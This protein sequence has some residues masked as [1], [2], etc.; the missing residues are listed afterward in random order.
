MIFI[1]LTVTTVSATDN[2]TNDNS[3]NVYESENYDDNSVVTNTISKNVQTQTK[4][5][6][7]E[8]NEKKDL[9][10]TLN[11]IEEV[12]YGNDANISGTFTDINGNPRI[13][14]KL[15]I[16]INDKSASAKT[17]DDGKFYFLTKIGKVGINN[18][19]VSHNGGTNFNPISVNTTYTVLKQ[20]LKITVDPIN[21]TS[22]GENVTITGTFTDENG[23]A[24]NGSKVKVEV[25]GKFG[26]ALVDENGTYTFTTVI[27]KIGI[28]NVT[29]SHKGGANF[30][31]ASINTTY[32][33]VKQDLKI[34]VDPI[35]NVGFGDNV[36][37]TGRFT[38][39]ND[40][41]RVN[42]KV[43]V[44]VNG[45]FGSAKTDS[46]GYFTFVTKLGALGIN[47]VT[48]SHPGGANYNPVDV[49]TTYIVTKQD[50]NINITTFK[51][52]DNGNVTISGIFTDASGK[53]RKNSNVKVVVNGKSVSAKT[54]SKGEF[55]Y[56]GNFPVTDMNNVTI[57]H[58]GGDNYNPLEY[59]NIFENPDIRISDSEIHP[60]VNKTLLVLV[61]TDAA[62]NAVFKIN[63]NTISDK[64]EVVYGMVYYTYPVPES[65]QSEEYLLEFTYSGDNKYM[66]KTV[67]ATLTLTPEGGRID[68]DMSMR[69]FSIKYLV[70]DVI[71]V[72][73]NDDAFGTIQFKAND[74][75]ITKIKFSNG[76]AEYEYTSHLKPGVYNLTAT[77]SG[78]YKYNPGIV[79]S[80]LIVNKLNSKLTMK[81]ITSKAGNY[82]LFMATVTDE[83]KQPVKKMNVTFKLNNTVIG[84]NFTDANGSVKLYY[85][86]PSSLYEKTYNITA[87]GLTTDTV[88]GSTNKAKLTLKQLTTK[89]SVPDTSTKPS[90]TITITATVIDEFNNYVSKGVVT[91]KKDNIILGKVNVSD[92]FAKFTYTTNYETSNKTYVYASYV[93][94]WKYAS[95]NGKG[96]YE[97]TQ[98]KTTISPNAINANP[99]SEIT[100][101]SIIRDQNQNYATDGSVR[102]SIN[103]TVIGTATVRNGVATLRH[104]LKEYVAGNYRIKAEYLGSKVYKP[105]SNTNTMIVSRYGTTIR[106]EEFYA[107]VG[108]KSTMSL[109]VVDDEKYNV[110]S[111]EVKFYLNNEYLGTAKVSNGVATLEYT[112]PSKYDGKTVKYYATYEKNGIYDSSS[113]SGNLVVTHQKTV[114]VSPTGS[115]SN[116]GDKAHPFKTIQYALTHIS[117]FGTI[118]LEPGTY[119]L[120]GLQLNTSVNLIG[121]G[122]DKTFIDGQKSGVPVFNITKRNAVLTI[123]GITIRN[124]KSNND[125]S[126]GAIVTSGKLNIVNSRF[127]N[128]TGSGNFSG[129]AIYTNGILNI[130]NTTFTNNIVTN[131][132]SQGGAIRCYDN[133]TYI[134]NCRFESNQVTGTNSTGASAIYG[135]YCDII[136][137]QTTFTKNIAKGKY[138]TGGVIR[139][140]AGAVVIDNSTFTNNQ[141]ISTDYGMGGIIGS[142]SSGISI[143]NSNINSNTIKATNNAG[144]GAVYVE[145]AA[146]D[147]KNTKINSNTLS[148]ATT[149]GGTIYS[150]KASVNI[151][152][153]QMN[154]NKLADTDNGYGGVVYAYEGGINVTNSNFTSNSIKAKSLALAGAIYTFS[155]VDVRNSNFEKNDINATNLGGG[156]IA[157]MGNLTVTNSNFIS[158]NAYNAGDAITATTSAKNNIENNYWGS[159]NP[160]WSNLLYSV[161]QPKT[162]SKTKL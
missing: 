88:I 33:V 106:G 147:I 153:T 99:N 57:T 73:L 36:T 65:F 123:K 160:N 58:P 38:D 55:T 82:T 143:M 61:P 79:N 13:N 25:N 162:Y 43:K 126:A 142:L 7:T 5:N 120:S 103:N 148:A 62:G 47:N 23:I 81:N 37:I 6:T 116:L 34:T 146:M 46:D 10:I 26:S 113:Y 20:D 122:R 3:L 115:D 121:S 127:V 41:P 94:D 72:E 92:G 117:L 108:S 139:A 53:V 63:K 78:N 56:T 152:D 30:N 129:G 140:I 158:N 96:T 67:N 15:K 141:I 133:T 76:S 2:I 71:S 24:R 137:N 138:V 4:T 12:K 22:F 17:N 112:V 59:N 109:S 70:K 31:P 68:A 136:I 35:A 60:G 51:E 97:V 21:Q 111:G 28:N 42:S 107:V 49:N 27:G 161:S 77:Y 39:A 16:N 124:A 64:L 87:T 9:S 104:T 151:I 18:V 89:V 145:T 29:I 1:I 102:Y 132:N 11:P 93:G 149:Y 134:T 131:V 119:S 100:L 86:L 130:T 85:T 32:S 48:L 50:L 84:S 125:F 74:I 69:N 144:G 156:A 14:S 66:G 19:T 80:T 135:D 157:N 101:S 159:N 155:V 44:M 52:E 90:K 40:K 75:N 128:N 8:T 154:S 98:L 91:F 118:Q 54:N 105:S 83:I 114:Y 95:S 45:K 110:N 150:Y